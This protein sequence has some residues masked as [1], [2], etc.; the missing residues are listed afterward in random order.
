MNVRGK[1]A[2]SAAS[3]ACA[4]AIAAAIA[5]SATFN[6]AAHADHF[7]GIGGT[8]QDRRDSYSWSRGGIPEGWC[9]D[10]RVG[11]TYFQTRCDPVEGLFGNASVCQFPTAQ[12]YTFQG[13]VTM[14]TSC[15][16]DYE[17]SD[18]ARGADERGFTAPTASAPA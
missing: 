1:F 5:I 6:S 13:Q 3:A 2:A 15:R 4:A 17:H 8:E 16:T 7:G 14:F 11:G 18:F 10:A 9:E 12:P